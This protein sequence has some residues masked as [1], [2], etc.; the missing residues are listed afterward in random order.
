MLLSRV[1]LRPP[2]G[3]ESPIS[4]ADMVDLIWLAVATTDRI[5]HIHARPA[6]PAVEIAFFTLAAE[7]KISDEIARRVC[8]RAVRVI[9]A[10]RGCST[11]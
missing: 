7:Q 11:E 6:G 9:P 4:P 10:L 5:E 8:E 2:E 3:P 1:T